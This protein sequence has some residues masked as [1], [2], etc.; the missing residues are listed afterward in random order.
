MKN[1][2]FDSSTRGQMAPFDRDA[3]QLIRASLRAVGELRDLALLN[4]G[5]DTMLRASDL[6]RIRVSTVRDHTGK[7]VGGFAVKQ[8]KTREMVHLGSR[9]ARGK[10]SQVS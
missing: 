4:V 8:K 10:R 2:D 5:V 1:T 7:I 9:S 3:L 6:V